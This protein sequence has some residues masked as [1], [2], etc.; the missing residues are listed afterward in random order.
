VKVITIVGVVLV[1]AVLVG[2]GSVALSSSTSTG[3]ALV[4]RTEAPAPGISLSSLLV[5]TRTI[6]LSEYR[7]K[8][9]VLNFWSSW[10]VACRIEMPLLESAY[11]SEHG[12]V[13]FLGI[14][15]NDTRNAARDFLAQVH[16]TYP[17]AFD[18]DLEA[19][20]AYGVFG[21]PVT[22]FISAG[23]RMLGRHIGQFDATTLSGALQR[24]FD[25]SGSP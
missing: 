19:A 7:G 25:R 13:S 10:C 12:K 9:L 5:P 21:L 6:S 3:S 23:G 11:L 24:A 16:V 1:L 8:E 2:F 17:C 14:D 4:D 18:P 22:V 20:S 15:T